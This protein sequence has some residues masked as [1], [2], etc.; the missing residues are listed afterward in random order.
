MAVIEK[1]SSVKH[2]TRWRAR[3][4][5]KG[6]GAASETFSSR[7]DAI[8]WA[9]KTEAGI[10]E[11]RF[12]PERASQSR[13][14]ADLI[15]RFIRET[16][17][18]KALRSA[19]RQSA[20]LAWWRAEIG[21][22]VL[23]DLRAEHVTNAINRL[24]ASPATR[25]AGKKG[26]RRDTGTTI[27]G[28]TANRYKAAFS[29]ACKVG[30]GGYGWLQANP[31]REI[32]RNAEPDGRKR[33]LSDDERERLL[34]ECAKH[35]ATLRDV[36][37]LSLATAARQ[38]ELLGLRWCDVDLDRPEGAIAKFPRTKTGGERVVPL[39]GEALSIMR[40]RFDAR[41]AGKDTDLIFRGRK[42]HSKPLDVQAI[43]RR[44]CKRA[45]VHDFHWHDLRHTAASELA[46]S[47][48]SIFEIQAV[49]GHRT[50]QMVQ[51]YVHVSEPHQREAIERMM[52]KRAQQ[53]EGAK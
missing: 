33:F 17:P 48:A 20:Y 43:F 13:T 31:C 38:G 6:G 28:A 5:L 24:M 8:A 34:A 40:E 25:P 35:G 44:A 3:V 16:L 11:G 9:R 49:T 23:S 14:A 51:R 46:K 37:V 52:S 29:A 32:T 1:R 41:P 12:F 53:G 15:D 22:V 30:V 26:R 21:S 45:G 27:T 50:L 47:G 39:V 18:R 7:K 19:A 4:R 36:V 42:N 10:I 2:G